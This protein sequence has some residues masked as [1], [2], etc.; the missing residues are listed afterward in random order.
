M[1]KRARELKQAFK[2]EE[3]AA[4]LRAIVKLTARS[5]YHIVAPKFEIPDLIEVFYSFVDPET[6]RILAL[7]DTLTNIPPHVGAPITM[8]KNGLRLYV[9]GSN[10]LPKFED[11]Q[12][13]ELPDVLPAYADAAAEYECK[14][15]EVQEV[16]SA[17]I[18][19]SNSPT[20]IAHH[21]PCVVALLKMGGKGRDD[22]VEVKRP[23]VLPA[24]M[25]EDVRATNSFVMQHMLLEPIPS[26][27]SWVGSTN[28]VGVF[29]D[30]ERDI[31][32]PRL[33]PLTE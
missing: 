11:L 19:E 20:T 3:V 24:S 17:L 29:F 15:E 21:W 25:I 9:Q 2:S 13:G 4:V 23:G 22:L 27:S 8:C 26:K 7:A 6:R 28:T 33:W 32:L 1:A 5:V 18:A 10:L 30:R 14:W 12:S 31:V 16:F